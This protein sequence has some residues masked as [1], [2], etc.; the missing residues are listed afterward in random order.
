MLPHIL[1]DRVV[2]KAQIYLVW[3]SCHGHIIGLETVEHT[4]VNKL[5][6]LT[7]L[8]LHKYIPLKFDVF[9]LVLYVPLGVIPTRIPFAKKKRKAIL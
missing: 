2:Q 6:K 9:G 3:Q 8:P 5:M 1:T 4:P 7:H